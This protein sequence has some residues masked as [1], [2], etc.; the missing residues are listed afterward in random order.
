MGTTHAP[1]T[2]IGTAQAARILG[3]SEGRIRQL[4]DA[5][6]LP[7]VRGPHG[8]VF[9]LGDV[10]NLAVDRRVAARQGTTRERRRLGLPAG[11][12]ARANMRPTAA[13][14]HRDAA[15]GGPGEGAPAASSSHHIEEEHD[16]G[17]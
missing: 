10:E 4:A 11:G 5:G 6:R 16:H 3:V 1:E 2:A 13:L 14:P 7:F 9:A 8:R 15:A 12:R 17:Y